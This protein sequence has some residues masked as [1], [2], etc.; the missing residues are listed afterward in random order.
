MSLHHKIKWDSE[1][2]RR[3]STVYYLDTEFGCLEW[4]SEYRKASYAQLRIEQGVDEFFDTLEEA[5][6]FLREGGVVLELNES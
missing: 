1:S 5:L 4:H 6:A 2:P 3:W